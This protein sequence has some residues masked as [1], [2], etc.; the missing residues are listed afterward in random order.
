MGLARTN[1]RQSQLNLLGLLLSLR[2]Q[3]ASL[4]TFKALNMID[5][6][7][8]DDSNVREAWSKY[9]AALNDSN[10]QNPPGYAA[11][12]EKRRDLMIEIVKS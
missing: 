4:E 7:F 11:R 9:Y 10:L 6:V 2:H 12:E 8:V 5:A 1:R 3:P